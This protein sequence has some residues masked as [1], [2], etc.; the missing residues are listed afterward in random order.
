MQYRP[1]LM[2]AQNESAVGASGMIAAIPTTAM[3]W[4]V[5]SFMVAVLPVRAGPP[6]RSCEAARPGS[7]IAAAV[8]DVGDGIEVTEQPGLGGADGVQG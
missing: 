1:F 4:A 8:E 5:W 2:L 6:R 3:G 7:G